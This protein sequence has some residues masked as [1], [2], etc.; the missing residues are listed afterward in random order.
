M[1]QPNNDKKPSL[2]WSTPAASNGSTP[3]TAKTQTS[4]PLTLPKMSPNNGNMT[5][6]YVGIF[7]GGLIVGVVVAWGWSSLRHANSV[8][9][10]A[11]NTVASTNSAT[12][13]STASTKNTSN[14]AALAITSPQHAG[15]SI[16]INHVEVSKPTWVV[17]Y[18]STNGKPG[19]VLGAQLFFTSGSGTVTLLRP[20]MAGKTYLVGRSIDNGDGKFQKASDHAIADANGDPELTPISAN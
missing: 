19:N 15:L 20:T 12:S 3:T 1:Q 13:T 11:K 9:T 18:D 7:V 14:S 2:S 17:V 6:R 4:T 10:N 16:A 8:A 5:A